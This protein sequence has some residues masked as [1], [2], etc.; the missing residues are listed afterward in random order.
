MRHVQFAA[1]SPGIGA[2]EIKCS[3]QRNMFLSVILS[4]GTALILMGGLLL[5]TAIQPVPEI[6]RVVT[7][8]KQGDYVTPITPMTKRI[9]TKLAGS[10]PTIP[11]FGVPIPVDDWLVDDDVV[12]ATTDQLAEYLNSPG[13]GGTGWNE[14]E[15]I[16]YVPPLV[17]M[18]PTEILE[19]A[20][21]MPIPVTVETP[22]YPELAERAG[23]EG[24]VWVKVLVD[25]QGF[26]R[27]AV[28]AKAS[29]T[30]AGFEEA[31]LAS[32]MN[33][34][35]RPALQNGRSV[36]VWLTYKVDFRLR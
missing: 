35:Y 27:Q 29:G 32:A 33:N 28:I 25:E 5:H 6:P 34:R 16:A 3:Y 36:M 4:S 1:N 18:P 26:V 17:E 22:V 19:F 14:N 8:N 23:I 21:E 30:S 9:T 7:V 12:F 2:L 15:N 20:E 10:T 31:A 24:R 13:G 11:D